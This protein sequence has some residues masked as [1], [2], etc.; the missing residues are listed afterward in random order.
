VS[1]KWQRGDTIIFTG[2]GVLN[3]RTDKVERAMTDI[4][5][6]LRGW[7]YRV[8]YVDMGVLTQEAADAM[9]VK[10]A[11]IERLRAEVERLHANPADYRYWEGRYRDEAAEN[12]RLREEN[13]G[14]RQYMSSVN[15]TLS[16]V[17]A[18][19]LEEAAKVAEKLPYHTG[20]G[21]AAAVRALK[22]GE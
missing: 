16:K 13:I 14:H 4:V 5:E 18:E 21:V 17:R 9:E 1:D 19:A 8:G 22:G 11:E 2:H 12:E 10:D 7:S 3:T 20:L 15:T 6:R